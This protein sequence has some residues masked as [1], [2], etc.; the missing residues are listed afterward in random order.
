MPAKLTQHVTDLQLPYE[1]FLNFGPENLTEAELLAVI[2][3]TGTKDTSA[4]ELAEK[5]LGTGGVKISVR[6]HTSEKA[7]GDLCL[8]N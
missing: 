7:E 3:R 8:L 5:V 1:R 2:L 6:Y 4:V